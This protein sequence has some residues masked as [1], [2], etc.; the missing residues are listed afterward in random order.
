M[1]DYSEQYNL[2]TRQLL[3]DCLSDD[4]NV[5]ISPFSIL[6]LL[7]IAA[8]SASGRTRE[9]ILNALGDSSGTNAPGRILSELQR[10]LSGKK[11][12]FSSANAVCVNEEFEKRINLSYKKLILKMYDGELFSSKQMKKDI[13]AWV[14]KKTFG[15]I[16]EVAPENVQSALLCLINAVAF[17]DAW[18]DPYDD[19]DVADDT[20]H[21]ADG[22]ESRV[23]MLLGCEKTWLEDDDFTGFTKKYRNEN[24]FVFM[25]LLPRAEGQEALHDVLQR[26]NF[27]RLYRSG[28]RAIVD[29]TMPEFQY[30][31]EQDLSPLCMKLGMKEAFT[32]SADFSPVSPDPLM[33][34]SILHKAYI[35][36]NQAGTKAAAVTVGMMTGSLPPKLEMEIREITLDRPFV[37]AIMHG[38]TGIPVFIGVVNHMG[39][40]NADPKRSGKLPE[41]DK[42]EK[43]ELPRG[44]AFRDVPM[45]YDLYLQPHERANLSIHKDEHISDMSGFIRGYRPGKEEEDVTL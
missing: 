37:F 22:T 5:L 45:Q 29:T 31:Y 21:N 41:A 9:E 6:L 36:V 8:D 20:F 17:D 32:P 28:R 13:D 43:E 39:Q 25:G 42:E 3:T 27:T 12:V 24:G 4:T 35:D 15:L 16:P 38:E 23:R 1:K 30:E 40:V 19:M 34:D 2:L 26:V 18:Q 10:H 44:V 11:K 14:N 33:V 7:A